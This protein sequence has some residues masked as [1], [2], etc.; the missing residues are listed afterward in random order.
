MLNNSSLSPLGGQAPDDSLRGKIAVV[1]GATRGAGRGIALALGSAGATVYC[2]GRSVRGATSDLGRVETIDETAEG[3][4]ARGGIGIA[5]QVDH[6]S[7]AQVKALFER[8]SREQNGSLDLLV[9][10]VWGGD[11]LSEW[12]IPFWEQSLDKGLKMLERAVFTH[13]ITSR[14]GVPLMVRQRRGLVIE[15][16]DGKTLDYRGNFFYD[17]AKTTVIRLAVAMAA[18]LRDRGVT[19]LALTPGFLRSEAVLDHFGV[20]ESNWRDAVAKDP[21]FAGSETPHYIGRAVVALACDPGVG[22]KGGQALATWDLA[23]E[24][25]F[26]DVDGTQPDWATFFRDRQQQEKGQEQARS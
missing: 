9:N 24:Y 12:G 25:G 23:R 13:I 4:T 26:T 17:L 22:G 8:I 5:V 1:A 14:Y 7:E 19:A 21:Y 10:D 11:S 16:T 6:T 20:T 2:T 18:E 15:I 3:V